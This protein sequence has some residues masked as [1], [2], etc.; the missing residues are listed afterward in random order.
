MNAQ[1]AAE[2]GLRQ[3]GIA[4]HGPAM[5]WGLGVESLDTFETIRSAI[6]QVNGA[7]SGL[8]ILRGCEANIIDFEGNLDIPP[9]LQYDLDIVLA[10]FHVQIRPRSAV[11]GMSFM[12]VDMLSGM[13]GYVAKRE[14]SRNTDTVIAA[15]FNN[16][17]DILTHPGLHINIDTAELTKA[18]IQTGTLLEINCHHADEMLAF[19]K[20]AARQGAYF[21][22]SSDA[23]RV[24]DSA[25]N[26][27]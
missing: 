12:V 26:R 20:F 18:S 4:D 21:V 1:A 3:L 14:R 23:Q 8:T 11:Q 15:L 16:R 7:Y 19:V 24:L 2:A 6:N 22:I 13:S 5:R 25:A 27:Y 10:G 9:Y 17:I